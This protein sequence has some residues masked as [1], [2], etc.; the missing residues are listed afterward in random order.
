VYEFTPEK[1]QVDMKMAQDELPQIRVVPNPYITASS[2]EPPLPPGITSGRGQRRIDFIHLPA[3]SKITIFTARGDH[4]ITLMQDG[5]IENG[6]VSW[7]LKSK[8][9]L[10]VAYGVYFYVVD[11]PVGK[12]TGK[13]AI[14]K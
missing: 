11:S 10:D 3:S 9:N 1:P 12:K 8:E 7:N 5:N 2:L 6:T 13:I 4:V 14:I